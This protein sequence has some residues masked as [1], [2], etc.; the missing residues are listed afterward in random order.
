MIHIV[1]PDIRVDWFVDTVP[2][3]EA[4]EI[5]CLGPGTRVGWCRDTQL[6]GDVVRD[7]TFADVAL[8]QC[9]VRFERRHDGEHAHIRCGVYQLTVELGGPG[10]VTAQRVRED[11]RLLNDYVMTVEV[12]T[13]TVSATGVPVPPV[14]VPISRRCGQLGCGFPWTP[15]PPPAP[16]PN[17]TIAIH[18]FV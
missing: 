15:P 4:R 18:N 16:C 11:G 6:R 9:D 17:N 13:V 14:L 2:P 10:D 1:A 12:M 7:Q 3:D 8:E 5:L